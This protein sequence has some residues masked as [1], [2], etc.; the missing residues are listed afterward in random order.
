MTRR[1]RA[2]T[3][4]VLVFV[5]ACVA[6][7]R[8]GAPDR[9]ER[10]RELA[11]SRLALAELADPENPAEAYREMYALLDE[12]IVE[13]L[14]AGGV[15][16]SLPFLQDRLDAFG[17]AWGGAQIRLLGLGRLVVGAFKLTDGA[18]GNSV[19]VYGRLRDETALLATMYRDGRPSLHAVSGNEQFL[20][21]WEGSPSG[22]GTR[23]LRVELV[24]AQD[25]GVRIAWSTAALFPDGLYAR[26]Y[27][28]R[29][30]DIRI[31]YE[32]RYPGWAP[33]CEGQ[34]EQEDQYRVVPGAAAVTR[35]SRHQ[36]NAWHRDFHVSVAATF[37]ALA[38][39]DDPALTT[40]VP[41]RELRAR[42]PLLSAEPVCDAADGARD[43]VSI[44]ASDPDRRPWTL[45]FRRAGARW[46]LTGASP[47]SP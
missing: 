20:A 22:R 10:F 40:L 26:A 17:D 9:L 30:P 31:R 16:A 36:Y 5:G 44:A 39:H 24:R 27:A 43:A 35:V 23:E 19:R 11:R 38:A 2:A 3:L 46:R 37:A 7:A 8:S 18:A 29:P 32:L 34:T 25:D 45:T 14:G 28:I 47:L 33:G 15:F 42:L 41:D 6:G 21:A 1:A 13:S 4:V 12:E